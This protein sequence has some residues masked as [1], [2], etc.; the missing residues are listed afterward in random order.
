MSS[1]R[2]TKLVCTTAVAALAGV[3]VAHA[4][5]NSLK[6]AA[7]LQVHA[8]ADTSAARAAADDA[9]ARARRLMRKG[10]GELRRAAR[11]VGHAQ[12]TA[13]SGPA[14]QAAV[15]AQVALSGDAAQQEDTLKAIAGDTSG[16]VKAAALRAMG[17]VG[18]VEARV[19]GDVAASMS[20]GSAGAQAGSEVS[21]DVSSMTDALRATGAKAL[22]RV[23]ERLAALKARLDKAVSASAGPS[24]AHAGAQASGPGFS[25]GVDV[26]LGLGGGR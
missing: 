21:G 24:G 2:L 19:S 20:Q 8:N 22:A 15:D 6:V 25:G 26:L 4:G 10:V 16:R 9:G 17:A 5:D 11:M 1:H 18:A 13:S 14:V 7:S 3:P 23:G 12:A